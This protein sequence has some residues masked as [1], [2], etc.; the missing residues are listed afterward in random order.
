[1]IYNKYIYSFGDNSLVILLLALYIVLPFAGYGN[2]LVYLIFFSLCLIMGKLLDDIYDENQKRIL[3]VALVLLVTLFSGLRNFGVGTDTNVYI[4][5]FFTDAQRVNSIK[6]LFFHSYNGDKGF[7]ALACFSRFFSSDPQ[8]FLIVIA[9]FICFFTFLAVAKLNY[10]EKKV[11]WT[12]F[13]FIWLFSLY[14]ESLNAMRQYCAMSILLL[15]FVFLLDNKWLKALALVIPAFFFHSSSIII[16]PIFFFYY[17]SYL[18][19]SKRF[20]L[21][22][23]FLLLSLFCVINA[24]K[25]LPVLGAQGLILEDYVERYGMYSNYKSANLFGPSFIVMYSIVCYGIWFSFKR[26]RLSDQSVVLVIGVH[27]LYFLLRLM[28]LHVGYLN[29]LSTYYFYLE[30]LF[31]SMF[32]TK[33]VFN[34][35][36]KMV[37]LLCIIFMW[38]KGFII[39]PS[40]E[41]YPYISSILGI[42]G[43]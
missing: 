10:K 4:M 2:S 6:D 24:M 27:A 7:L 33:D 36:I 39:N 9:L 18:P 14:N 31:L 22:G 1:M 40:G 25:I 12:V 37:L 29:R 5:R 23:V 20:F 34:E 21:I 3:F 16:L 28:A 32:W 15:S 30:V 26:G 42:S 43:K 19:S 17:I 8:C 11:N 13:L 35:N 41:T 38:C